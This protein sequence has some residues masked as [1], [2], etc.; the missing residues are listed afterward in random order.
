MTARGVGCSMTSIYWPDQPHLTA[1]EILAPKVL[2]GEQE[3]GVVGALT[4]YTRP[5]NINGFPAIS[6][7]CGFSDTGMPIGLQ[8]AGKPFDE[9]TV[10]RAA[11]AYEQA[12]D[13]HTR[14]PP[15]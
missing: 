13:W 2:A 5:Y 1:P 14:R 8:L 7:P 10:L 11:H 12:T 15:L 4:Q 6:V 9:L 3:I